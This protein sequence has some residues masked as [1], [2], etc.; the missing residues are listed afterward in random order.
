M[1][2]FL[3]DVH[4]FAPSVVAAE[5]AS[6]ARHKVVAALKDIGYTESA[7]Y[8]NVRISRIP[9]HDEWAKTAKHCVAQSDLEGT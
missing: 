7:Q 6:K 4:G 2:A 3:A 9:R 1:K 5:T 8:K